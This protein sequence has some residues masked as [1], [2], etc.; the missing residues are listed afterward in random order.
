MAL[1]CINSEIKPD[2]G[3]KSWFCSY[4][5]HS[6]PPLGCPRQNITI[7][8]G[9]G[10]TRMVGLPDGEKTLMLCITVYTQYRRVTDGQTDRQTSCHGIVRTMHTRRAVKILQTLRLQPIHSPPQLRG[11]SSWQQLVATIF[12]WGLLT[13]I[14]LVQ[15]ICFSCIIL[16]S[17]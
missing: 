7:P 5:L 4:P 9:Y 12:R 13:I 2:I 1:S 16:V 10:K 6:A 17:D 15:K 11:K 14:Y 3:R 8:L